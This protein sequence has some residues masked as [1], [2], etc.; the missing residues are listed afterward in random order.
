[1]LGSINGCVK[2]ESIN[3]TNR[4]GI[5]PIADGDYYVATWGNDTSSG[6][7][8]NPWATWQKAFNTA[9]PGDIVYFRG[10]V[11][12]PTKSEYGGNAI[13]TIDPDNRFGHSG[14]P[15]NPICY[16]NYPGE[17]PVLD[18][19]L[20]HPT[21][22]FNTALY[23]ADC[24][25][26]NWRGIT[27]RNVWQ[28]GK[29]V[30]CFGLMGW[31]I[32]N[33]TFDRMVVHGIAGNAI[34]TVSDANFM[35]YGFGW[36]MGYIPYDTTR[37]INCDTY[38]NNDTINAGGDPGNAGD[39]FK[40]YSDEGVGEYWVYSGCRAWN[41]SDDGFDLGSASFILIENCWSFNNG[42]VGSLDGNGF[43]TGG[44][45]DSISYPTRIVR[46]CL[47]AFNTGLGFYDIDYEPYYRTNARFY[48]NTAI[49]CKFGFQGQTTNK[50]KPWA[51]TQYRN[52]IAYKMSD[53][54]INDLG[55]YTWY[56]ENHNTWDMVRTNGYPFNIMTDSV[57]VKDDDFVSLIPSGLTGPRQADGSLP[58]I[59]FLRLAKGSDL[60]G[61]G[62]Y[63][64]MSETPPMGIDWDFIDMKG[65]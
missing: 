3:E 55:I 30:E 2:D 26:I 4:K 28:F 17:I 41:C 34:R 48:N 38:N 54:R 7:F 43:K 18:C 14:T 5:G 21:G 8:D 1:M 53:S 44:I 11:W 22:K 57:K 50:P 36:G 12:Y 62:T 29:A 31:P 37:F 33:M 23:I 58:K 15:E 19:K 46:N 56:N 49:N 65:N 20:F 10:G 47:T 52:N 61:V 45:K 27:I 63:V 6:S 40:T 25:F 51:L 64:G 24:H 35:G 60:I 16:Y 59:N 42:F 9:E 32:S 39:G 13:T